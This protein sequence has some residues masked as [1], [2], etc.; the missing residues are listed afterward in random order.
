MGLYRTT[1]EGRILMANP[2]LV[3]SW[4]TTRLK[5][6][7]GATWQR[8]ASRRNI[9]AASF[10]TT[11]NADG[12]VR[13]IRIGLAAQDGAT[14]HV[15]QKRP[16]GAG[17]QWPA[18]PLRRH[19]RRHHRSQARRNSELVETHQ[20]LEAVLRAVP[21]GV[22]FSDDPTCQRITGN[23]A[24]LAQFE[25][26]PEDN[27][28]ASAS[29]AAAPA[30]QVRYFAEGR[31][32]SDAELPLQR[33]VAENQEVGPSS[34]RWSCPAGVLVCAGLRRPHP[35][36][37]GN[38]VGGVAVTEDVTGRKQARR[39]CSPS[40]PPHQ[41][42]Q[43]MSFPGPCLWPGGAQAAS[44]AKSEFLANMSHEIRT[45]MTAII[46]FTDSAR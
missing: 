37:Q 27:L 33:A 26:T 40:A 38:V 6:W 43:G 30:R 11:S 45:P 20:R 7:P 15:A 3:G 18:P 35:R 46:G 10:R 24:V 13:G 31:Q 42:A 21:V 34:L 16:P 41:A 23:P 1:P 28:S 19:R 5:S 9:P 39:I 14:I 32:L 25:V 29:D 17:R 22:S 2:V 12:E 8:R 36:W 4:A 44:R